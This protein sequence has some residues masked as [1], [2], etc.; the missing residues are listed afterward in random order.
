MTENHPRSKTDLRP[1]P[2]AT[3]ADS[4][5]GFLGSNSILLSVSDL[6]AA[7]AFYQ[8]ATGFNLLS[9]TQVRDDPAVDQLYCSKAVSFRRA[10]LRAPNM[11][12]ELTEFEENIGTSSAK[13][14]VQ[15]PGMTHT[16]YQTPSTHSGYDRFSEA[17]A[18]ILST[19][20]GPIDLGGYGVT[21]AYA[22][23]PDGNMLE[24]EQLD[25]P[26]LDHMGY[27]QSPV[28]N[29]A[30]MW[31]SQ[32]ALVSP[33]LDRLMGFYADLFGIAPSRRAE[34]K[35]N[36]RA[37]AIA[38]LQNAHILGG[39]FQLN[40]KS[41]VLEL[42]QYIRPPSVLLSD[43]RHPRSL[44]Y[45]FVLEVSN[46]ALACAHLKAVSGARLLSGPIAFETYQAAYCKDIDG[47]VFCLR[48][49]TGDGRAQSVS[50]LDR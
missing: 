43:G 25:Q 10:I 9:S 13:M 2:T 37:D 6:D 33:D 39:W 42:W 35:D 8:R 32:I 12:L 7:V 5:H 49:M 46:I 24:L 28:L 36:P 31:L 11:L 3:I 4:P 19:G 21:Y 22:H 17:G 1:D 38:G 15:G 23:D 18:S 20:D 47:N 34:I 41:K 44:G 48:E 27:F 14:P 16:C 50:V 30:K 26:V 40:D 29:G 45:S